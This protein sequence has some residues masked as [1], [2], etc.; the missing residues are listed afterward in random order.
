MSTDQLHNL[1]TQL[2]FLI[3][4]HVNYLNKLDDSIKQRAVFE[5]KKHTD[6]NFGKL[7]YSEVWPS[8]NNYP[9]DIKLVIKDIEKEHQI[10]HTMASQVNTLEPVQEKVDATTAC[11]LILK[12]YHLEDLTNKHI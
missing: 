6:C 4:Q 3:L 9:D 7:F 8:L 11:K 5:H 10:F 12:L 2:D 1:F